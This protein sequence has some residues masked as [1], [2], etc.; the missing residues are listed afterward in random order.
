M[1]IPN[2]NPDM[3][4]NSDLREQAKRLL[5]LGNLVDRY[6]DVIARRITGLLYLLI[7]GGVS[8][9]GFLFST[10]LAFV[11]GLA[12]N[13]FVIAGFVVAVMGTTWVLTFKLINPLT[14][15][16]PRSTS[17]SEIQSTA[18]KII[19]LVLACIMVGLTV[20][21]FGTNQH[22]L[23]PFGLQIVL[24]G[25]NVANYLNVK[26]DPLEAPFAKAHLVFALSIVLSIIPIWVFLDLGF[27]IL[28]LVDLG[29]I[30]VLGLY[31]LVSAERLLIESL[32]R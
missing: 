30:Y 20:F 10:L 13:L 32:G 17:R 9:A 19:W 15:S 11:G 1:T 6:P 5:T 22:Q 21:T 4:T 8:L 27:L 2:S 16:Y 7:A 29:G 31:M 14:Q 28:I 18:G 3:D 26:N 24:T 23:F 25:V 12:N